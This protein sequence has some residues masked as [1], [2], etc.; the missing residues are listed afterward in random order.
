MEKGLVENP[1]G[2]R[3]RSQLFGC[4]A[5]P[6]LGTKDD[7]WERFARGSVTATWSR[8][9]G[10]FGSQQRQPDVSGCDIRSSALARFPILMEVE[11]SLWGSDF[12][13][14]PIPGGPTDV[15]VMGGKV[16]GRQ[17]RPCAS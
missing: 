13:L 7:L 4:W 5:L 9:V 10:Q 6:D 17:Q 3:Q 14:L 2:L 16:G 8:S 11:K 12:S 15:Y 1:L